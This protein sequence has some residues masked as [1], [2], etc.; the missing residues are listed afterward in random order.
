MTMN[1]ITM[2]WSDL[3]KVEVNNG[4]NIH[5][6]DNIHKSTTGVISVMADKQSVNN[7]TFNHIERLGI[8]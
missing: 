2:R 4:D 7:Y 1:L 6:A 5:I 3:N 8:G